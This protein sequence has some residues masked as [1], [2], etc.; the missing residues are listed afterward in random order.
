MG[1]EMIFGEGVKIWSVK[2]FFKLKSHFYWIFRS[3]FGRGFAFRWLG[4]CIASSQHVL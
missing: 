4:H 1:P 2:I 3:E